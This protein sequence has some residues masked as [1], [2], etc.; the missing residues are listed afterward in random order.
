[1]KKDIQKE[2]T[3]KIIDLIEEHGANWTKPFAEIGGSPTNAATGRKYRG[4]NA[5]WLGLLGKSVVAT[6]K[7]WQSLGAQVLGNEKGTRI[8]V[9][10]TIKD[11]DTGEITGTW[12]G[13]ANVYSA[14]QVT[15]WEAPTLPEIDHTEVLANVDK[16][17]SNTGAE[18]KVSAD[19]G[20]YFSPA[21][22][23]IHMLHRE[24]F[25]ATETSS[26]TECF[27]STELHE[28]V[29]W[30][31]HKS[32]LDRLELKNKHGY[33]FEELVAEVGSA[34]LCA[35]LGVSTETRPDHA[36]YIA[37]WLQALKDDKT[38]IYKAAGQA[39]KAVDFLHTLQEQERVAA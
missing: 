2:I 26:A 22:D 28:L 12:F 32:R 33:A 3:E 38:F 8:S 9:P 19:G 24:Q 35:D 15:G 37:N 11:K 14:D 21:G 34:I 7:Q 30:S 18:I 36:Q 5:F 39:Q 13:S 20:C 6:Y 16:F 17:I 29:H 10:M 23:F 4:V 1:M 25:G 31:G 27:Y